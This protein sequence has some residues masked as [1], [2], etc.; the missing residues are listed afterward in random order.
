MIGVPPAV[1][2]AVFLLGYRGMGLAMRA[3]SFL[4][5]SARL[6]ASTPHG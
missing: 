1:D 6:V 4:P 3:G 2:R 5:E